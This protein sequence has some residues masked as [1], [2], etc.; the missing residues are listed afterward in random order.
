MNSTKA[1]KPSLSHKSFHHFIVTRLPN[2]YIVVNW[3]NKM[4]VMLNVKELVEWAGWPRKLGVRRVK[5]RDGMGYIVY[6]KLLLL[7]I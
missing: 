3:N 7:L 5:D 2:H 6:L 4:H 1:A